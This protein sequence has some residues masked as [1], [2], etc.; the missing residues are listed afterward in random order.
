MAANWRYQDPPRGRRS[1]RSLLC[2]LNCKEF[3]GSIPAFCPCRWGCIWFGQH[4]EAS[5]PMHSEVTGCL[6]PQQSRG[7]R[8]PN[9]RGRFRLGVAGTRW[10]PEHLTPHRCSPAALFH[11]FSGDPQSP[12]Q[13]RRPMPR[14][15]TLLPQRASFL[16][17]PRPPLPSVPRDL[18]G[19]GGKRR[20]RRSPGVGPSQA[21][22]PDWRA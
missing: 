2:G 19:G 11:F 7:G 20:T 16:S 4:G 8:M 14:V 22:I 17:P 6:L 15:P 13:R 18:T 1:S 5:C 10:W 21:V 3:W 12:F 9:R